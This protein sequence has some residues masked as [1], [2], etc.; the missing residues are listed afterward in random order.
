[1]KLRTLA[2]A[3]VAATLLTLAP[4]I[5]SAAPQDFALTNS[6]GYDIKSVFISPTASDEWGDDV[7]GQDELANGAEATIH[8]PGGRGE[9]CN[10]D[11]KVTYEDNT[12][13]EWKNFDLC[14]ISQIDIT[15]DKDAGTTSATWK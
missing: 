13:A 4:A 8:F 12:T 1:M 3:T 14:T 9:T 11:L 2:A 15:Y 7:L 6:T 10:W 5:A